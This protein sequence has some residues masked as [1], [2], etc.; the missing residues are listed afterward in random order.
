[1]AS[2]KNNAVKNLRE[3]ATTFAQR[4]K[5]YGASYTRHGDVMRAL[6]PDGITLRTPAEFA[7]FGVVNMI[8]SKVTRYAA[9]P[10]KGHKDSA[11]DIMVYGAMLEE[12]TP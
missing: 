5:I 6:Y 2:S 4:N 1:M 10:N 9:H 8:V 12:L 7:N 3:G 11:H